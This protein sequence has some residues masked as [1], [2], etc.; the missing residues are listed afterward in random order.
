MTG[1]LLTPPADLVTVL[2]A[3]DAASARVEH[4]GGG[5]INETLRVDDP[6]RGTFV[7]QRLNPV[8]A[9]EVNEDID[10]ITAHLAAREVLTPRL[11]RTTDGRAWASAAG[12]VWRALSWVDGVGL[13]RLTTPVQA[14]AAGGTLAR[15]HR[16]LVDC[17]HVFRARR[18]GVHDTARHLERLREALRA[19][20]NHARHAAIAPLAADIL[21]AAELLP[22]LAPTPERVVHGDPKAN[23]LLFA[24]GGERA[25]CLVDLDTV[26]PMALPLELGDAFRSWCNPAGEDAAAA[27]FSLALFGPALRGYA[28]VAREFITPAEVAGIVPATETIYVELAA[29]FCADALNE[30]YFGWDATRYATRGDHNEARARSQLAAARSLATQRGSAQALVAGAFAR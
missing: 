16:A 15:F 1:R 26:A 8:F 2:T 25:L 19:H 20:A 7:L 28:A 23:N 10:A 24:P 13:A 17:R 3:W 11:L 14:E 22:P 21:A 5:L 27:V 6:R 12:G 18:H 4:L 29:R 9:P 30:N